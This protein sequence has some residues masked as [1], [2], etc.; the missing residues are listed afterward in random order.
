MLIQ[1]MK[2]PLF[3]SS[4][5]RGEDTAYTFSFKTEALILNFRRARTSLEITT[6]ILFVYESIISLERI[7]SFCQI[8]RVGMT[9]PWPER[10]APPSHA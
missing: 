8:I 3:P 6:A 2:L 4:P 9:Q 5:E 10:T 7:H 1:L